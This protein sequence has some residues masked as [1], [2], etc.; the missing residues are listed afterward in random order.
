MA[1]TRYMHDTTEGPFYIELGRDNRWHIQWD[2]EI[3]G[4]YHSP[5]VALANL[6][7]GETYLSGCGDPTL[8]GIADDLSKWK[9]LADPSTSH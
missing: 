1:I 9:P 2:G 6:V 7:R 8:L 4:S 5:Q 3:L